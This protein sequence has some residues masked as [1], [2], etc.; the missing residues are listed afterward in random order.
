VQSRQPWKREHKLTLASVFV[1]C[2]LLLWNVGSGFLDRFSEPLV[3]FLAD[4]S[5][6]PRTDIALVGPKG[7]TIFPDSRGMVLI[8]RSWAGKNLPVYERATWQEIETIRLQDLGDEPQH[9]TIAQ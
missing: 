6:K 1:A 5:K 4:E 7:Q 3:V 2:L 8:P 9:R